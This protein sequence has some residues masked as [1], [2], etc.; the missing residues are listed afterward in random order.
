M[1]SISMVNHVVGFLVEGQEQPWKE[2]GEQRRAQA[3]PPC[4]TKFS[5]AGRAITCRDLHSATSRWGLMNVVMIM[6]IISQ[7]LS[8]LYTPGRP[9][10]PFVIWLN[11]R[12]DPPSSVYSVMSSHARRRVSLLYVT[13]VSICSAVRSILRRGREKNEIVRRSL[14]PPEIEARARGWGLHREYLRTGNIECEDQIMKSWH[15]FV[16]IPPL[17]EKNLRS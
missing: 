9:V 16:Y 8:H 5:L 1:C 17:P 10:L 15:S 11:L 13:H 2:A 7:I 4:R 14:G 12:G 6:V 3:Y